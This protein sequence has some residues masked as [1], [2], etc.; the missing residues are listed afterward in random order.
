MHAVIQIRVAGVYACTPS[1]EQG[2]CLQAHCARCAVT[3]FVR[4][5]TNACQMGAGGGVQDWTITP[6]A[7]PAPADPD[8][9][10]KKQ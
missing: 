7:E 4:R 5:Y 3:D 8:K 10:A 6:T 1:E 9:K 2:P